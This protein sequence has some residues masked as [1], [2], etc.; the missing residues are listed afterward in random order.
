MDLFVFGLLTVY[1]VVASGVQMIMASAAKTLPR[2]KALFIQ[3]LVC[4]GIGIVLVMITGGT[5]LGSPWW[6]LIIPLGVVNSFGAYAQWRA[7]YYGGAGKTAVVMPLSTVVAVVMAMLFLGEKSVF[8]WFWFGGVVALVIA[9]SLLRK[10]KPRA[11]KHIKSETLWLAS[12]VAM[13]VIVGVVVAPGQKFFANEVSKST[14]LALLYS[15]SL[16]GAFMILWLERKDKRPFFSAGIWKVPIV[17]MGVFAAMGLLYWMFQLSKLAII[18]P[19]AT[20]G[21]PA[22]V[23]AASLVF[24]RQERTDLTGF[25]KVGFVLGILGMIL[26]GVDLYGNKSA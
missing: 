11:R 18:Y 13:V 25:Q 24:V 17:S 6:L 22:L 2:A 16:L 7:Y 10:G 20:F 12:V 8:N 4:A 23:I 19:L 15:G 3:Y 21:N 9:A 26:M 14:F 1:L 5:K